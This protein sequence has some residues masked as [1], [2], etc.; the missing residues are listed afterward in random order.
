MLNKQKHLFITGLLIAFL[1]AGAFYT[2]RLFIGSN[3]TSTAQNQF[4]DEIE[5][6]IESIF[7]LIPNNQVPTTQ[8]LNQASA[9]IKTTLAQIKKLPDN[10]TN[11]HYYQSLEKLNTHIE[12][13]NKER[14]KLD[15]NTLNLQPI[16]T[17]IQT[18]TSDIQ[19]LINQFISSDFAYESTQ[20]L[21][22][23][24]NLLRTASQNLVLIESIESQ[25]PY[26]TGLLAIN[27]RAN[28]LKVIG[29]SSK[30]FNVDELDPRLKMQ[31]IKIIKALD[32]H[33]KSHHF[34]QSELANLGVIKENLSIIQEM[35]ANLKPV[36]LVRFSSGEFQK[37]LLITMLVIIFILSMRFSYLYAKTSQIVPT[38]T[39]LSPEDRQKAIMELIKTKEKEFKAASTKPATTQQPIQTNQPHN[40]TDTIVISAETIDSTRIMGK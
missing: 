3:K 12:K 14:V 20:D 31:T 35:K 2:Y 22:Q 27:T 29:V 19:S 15:R 16:I 28:L 30:G 18:S 33:L 37:Q 36:T 10:D 8:A 9:K 39:G 24:L 13:T 1:S 11:S 7:Y 17:Q 40:Q 21:Q 5:N 34:F 25:D 38:E 6:N 23:L 4:I 26:T 32:Q